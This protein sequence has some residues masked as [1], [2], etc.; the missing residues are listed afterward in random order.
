MKLDNRYMHYCR[1][2]SFSSCFYWWSSFISCI[3]LC[4]VLVLCLFGRESRQPIWVDGQDQVFHFMLGSALRIRLPF[5][6]NLEWPGDSCTRWYL[7]LQCF[8]CGNFVLTAVVFVVIISLERK[9]SVFLSSFVGSFFLILSI[10]CATRT[11]NRIKYV[12]ISGKWSDVKSSRVIFTLSE[13]W[14]H[15]T[16][17]SN[18]RK[19]VSV[20][21]FSLLFEFWILLTEFKHSDWRVQH[22]CWSCDLLFCVLF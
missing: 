5:R 21:C 16:C 15:K 19:N 18:F 6:M 9:F 22:C 8:I 4:W 14:R 3:P 11:M 20:C 12:E 1:I 17:A 2:I 13:C 10:R 7:K